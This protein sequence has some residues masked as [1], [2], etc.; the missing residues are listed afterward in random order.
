MDSIQTPILLVQCKAYQSLEEIIQAIETLLK[1][2]AHQ[3]MDVYVSLPYT[4]LKPIAEKFKN[5]NLRIGAEILLDADEG[6]FTEEIVGKILE[7]NQAKF[8]LIGTPQDRFSHS[9]NSNHLNTKVKAALKAHVQPFICIG[10][11]LEEHQDKIPKE[12]LTIQ[13]KECLEN[14]SSE[15]LKKIKIVYNA[16]WISRTPWEA[17]NPQLIE[18]YKTFTEVAE[19]V[20]TSENMT[21]NQ[22]ILAVPAY[23]E[24]VSELVKFLKSPPHSFNGFSIGIL[25]LS[26][27]F[28]QPLQEKSLEE[29]HLIEKESQ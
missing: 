20:L 27:E 7:V 16:E 2:Q 12:I 29:H 13:L 10:E 23:S 1:I 6:S 25:G 3:V 9:A 19:E 8:A 28:L 14:I 11:T 24:D 15:D 26:S 5:H 17:T 4:F 18:A 22:L 21:K